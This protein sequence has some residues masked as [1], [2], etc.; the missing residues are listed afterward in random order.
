MMADL[1]KQVLDDVVVVSVDA[2]SFVD[3]NSNVNIL[4][5]VSNRGARDQVD[6]PVNLTVYYQEY[7]EENV[8]SWDEQY[9]SS[10]QLEE[11][12]WLSFNYRPTVTGLHILEVAAILDD[13]EI[14][15]DNDKFVHFNSNDL[16]FWDD[17]EGGNLG[18]TT[19]TS[20]DK[21]RWDM[22]DEY[23]FGSYSPTF[24]HNCKK[25]QRIVDDAR[26]DLAMHVDLF[27]GGA[28]VPQVMAGEHRRELV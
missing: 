25:S 9:I 23:P 1:S 17:V 10:L 28:S 8:V 5:N 4:V 7:G 15:E 24:P 13:D 26:Q 18:W 16:Y 22:I 20:S 21:Y 12:Q 6:L 14:P 19:N 3:S 27:R 2:D 11:Y